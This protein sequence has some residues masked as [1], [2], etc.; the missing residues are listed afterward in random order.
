MCIALCL[1]IHHWISVR[2]KDDNGSNSLKVETKA[3]CT[4]RQKKAKVG[5]AHC[6][7]SIQQCLPFIHAGT[8][9]L[10]EVTNVNR[11]K[12]IFQMIESGFLYSTTHPAKMICKIEYHIRLFEEVLISRI[13]SVRTIRT[14]E[15]LDV[16]NR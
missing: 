3:S 7:E 14:V 12:R 16:S 9:I 5:C 4:F 10:L 8:S 11:R 2:S 13:S 15:V 1:K 6:I